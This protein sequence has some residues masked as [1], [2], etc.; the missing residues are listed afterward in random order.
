MTKL[1]LCSCF[2]T[3]SSIQCKE[4]N[5]ES[6]DEKATTSLE[7]PQNSNH[8]DKVSDTQATETNN[9]SQIND[10][11][12]EDSNSD[13]AEDLDEKPDPYSFSDEDENANNSTLGDDGEESIKAEEID[14]AG[15]R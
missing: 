5:A 9:S 14:P 12:E 13:E 4:E 2:S 8:S 3:T 1:T 11:E 7:Q 6:H 10:N 15:V